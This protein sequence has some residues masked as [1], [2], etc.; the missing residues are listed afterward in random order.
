MQYRNL[1]DSGLRVSALALGCMSFGDPGAGTHPW[2][3]PRDDALPLLRQAFDAGLNFLDTA[4]IYSLGDSERIVGHAAREFGRSNVVLATKVFEPM[5]DG[6]LAGGLSRHSIMAE[7]DNSLRRLDTE[8]IDLYIIHRWDPTTP[9]EETMRAL[10]DLVTTGKVRY[11]G[12]S[13]MHAWQFAKAQQFAQNNGLTTFIS[14]QDHYN[15]I[16]REEE[17]EMIPMCA[18]Q[19]VGVTPWSP[20]ARGKLARTPHSDDTPRVAGDP[21]QDRFYAATSAADARVIDAVAAVAAERETSMAAVSLAWL[22]Q[23]PA[24]TSPIV[25]VTKPAHLT[26]ALNALDLH[27]TRDEVMSL[28]RPYLPHTVVEYT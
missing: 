7:V 19:G 14:M 15:L 11:I 10:H 16:N 5:H 8:Y 6:P 21:I 20:L 9:I 13:S 25:G 28:E 18:D 1:G 17:R 23:K 4:N 24:V 12:A 26:A 27:L 22:L 2:T 3:L